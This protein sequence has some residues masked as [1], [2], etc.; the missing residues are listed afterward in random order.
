MAVFT[1]YLSGDLPGGEADS[2]TLEQA[3]FLREGFSWSAFLFGPLWLVRHHLWLGFAVWLAAV[4]LF[5]L[6]AADHLPSAAG[7][8]VLV[9]IQLLLG[10]EGNHLRE[11]GLTR[12]GFHLADVVAANRQEEAEHAFFRFAP[13]AKSDAKSEG[14]SRQL[15]VNFRAADQNHVLGLFPEA[16]DRR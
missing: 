10:F 2:A 3:A 13:E 11:A 9:L 16:E 5:G 7:F 1:V 6:F 14:K 8:A 4:V 15:S 12:R